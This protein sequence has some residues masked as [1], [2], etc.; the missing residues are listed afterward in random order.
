M[1]EIGYFKVDDV[2]LRDPPA[3]D[4]CF[5]VVWRDAEMAEYAEMGDIGRREI[6]HRHMTNEI[7]S[8]DIAADCLVAFPDAPWELRMELARQQRT[9]LS[10]TSWNHDL[11]LT[12]LG[13]LLF[14][15][16]R[17]TG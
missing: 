8:I 2:I 11:H 17:S 3:R 1:T 13:L 16:V 5:K 9:D 15:S 6:L 4:S 14:L 12:A 10:G 7:T